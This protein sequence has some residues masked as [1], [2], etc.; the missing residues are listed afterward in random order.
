MAKGKPDYYRSTV[1]EG[2]LAGTLH[3]VKIDATGQLYIVMTGQQISVDNL[4]SDYFKDGEDIG[5]ITSNVTVDQSDSD[6]VIQGDDAGNKRYVAVDNTGVILARLKGAYG[7]VLKDISV[8]DTGIILARLKGSF[9]GV[10]KD[11]NVDTNGNLIAAVKGDDSGTLRNIYV[12]STGKMVAR[13]QGVGGGVIPLFVIDDGGDENDISEWV[14]IDDGLDPVALSNF[15]KEGVYSMKL[16]IDAD[17]SGADIASWEKTVAVGDMS[18]YLAK[19]VYAWVY[20]S[21]IDWLVT[22]DWCF[23]YKIGSGAG[24]YIGF[25]LYKADF[26]VGWNLLT[27]D[28]S[29]PSTTAGTVDWSNIDYQRIYIKTVAGNT[30]DFYIV[31]DMLVVVEENPNTGTLSDVVVDKDGLMLQKLTGSYGELHKP[32]ATDRYGNL[33][34]NITKRDL[35]AFFTNEYKSPV[36]QEYGQFGTDVPQLKTL[37]TLTG[38][39]VILGGM[40]SN[41]AVSTHKTATPAL[42]IDGISYLLR[43][44][45]E[46][47]GYGLNL[48]WTSYLY[49][50]KYDDDDYLYVAGISNGIAFETS[51][52]L[53]INLTISGTNNTVWELYYAKLHGV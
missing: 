21:T 37:I 19:N 45:Y 44:Y 49:N 40:I 16:G 3:P 2:D 12:D 34:V 7:G 33:R 31:L 25:L 39:G 6:R 23:Y 18:Q 14:E 46:L 28:L 29:S 22:G 38:P 24:D 20:V 32:V 10:L 36:I 51:A 5:S 8:D 52:V 13:C 26:A 43:S 30:H 35:G 53:K 4:P 50:L 11:I 41:S 15:G 1:I 48:P 27:F 17:R 47:W 9:G 42:D